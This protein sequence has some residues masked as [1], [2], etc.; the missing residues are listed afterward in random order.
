M[1]IITV[2]GILP[3]TQM[4][5]NFEPNT[6]FE[7]YLDTF[8]CWFCRCPAKMHSCAVRK[9][10]SMPRMLF[11]VPAAASSLIRSVKIQPT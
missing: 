1:Q 4:V 3:V 10:V 6:P 11:T 8:G 9:W 2:M 7:A 5:T